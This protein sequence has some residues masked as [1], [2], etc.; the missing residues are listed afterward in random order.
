MR[1]LDFTT[2]SGVTY[3]P[4]TPLTQLM[5]GAAWREDGVCSRGGGQAAHKSFMREARSGSMSC[6]ILT[7]SF[8]V[9][10]HVTDELCEQAP[11]TFV[12]SRGQET[13]VL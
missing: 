2:R 5:R 12:D 7:S 13:L 11:G 1:V 4:R 10:L 3:L 6:T 9:W 8:S